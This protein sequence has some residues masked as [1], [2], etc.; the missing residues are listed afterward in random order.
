MHT[1][2]HLKNW[3][4]IT[5]KVYT[6]KC[7]YFH[8]ISGHFSLHKIE[9]CVWY[10]FYY[11][12]RSVKCKIKCRILFA[13]FRSIFSFLLRLAGDSNLKRLKVKLIKFQQTI[14]EITTNLIHYLKT[15]S[16][17]FLELPEYICMTSQAINGTKEMKTVKN[18]C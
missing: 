13:E 8:W 4:K 11:V 5:H 2:M 1:T 9:K 7:V 12:S 16:P 6:W 10:F 15:M 14:S 18:C 3:I 17:Q